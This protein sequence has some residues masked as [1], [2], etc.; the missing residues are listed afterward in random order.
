MT[1]AE[2]RT[3]VRRYMHQHVAE[4]DNLTAMAEDAALAFEQDQWLD[5]PDH[6]IWELAIEVTDK[7][8]EA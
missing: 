6:W 7:T 1:E 5:D 3:E 4:H 8:E 2:L